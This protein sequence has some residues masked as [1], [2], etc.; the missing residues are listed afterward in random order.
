MHSF[1]PFAIMHT[2]AGIVKRIRFR[3]SA[4][5]GQSITQPLP[6]PSLQLGDSSRS[7]A[8][9]GKGPLHSCMGVPQSGREGTS[10][11]HAEFGRFELAAIG[12]LRAFPVQS[13]SRPGI[14]GKLAFTH[15]TD[16]FHYICRSEV[17]P[18]AANG[19]LAQLHSQR[20]N[21]VG[22]PS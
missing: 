21:A 8:V 3:P 1:A 14:I 2:T 19:G 7:G 5:P 4:A 22:L 9:F 12:C 16:R 20:S 18:R 15:S 10:H 6:T 13:N 17:G 11:R